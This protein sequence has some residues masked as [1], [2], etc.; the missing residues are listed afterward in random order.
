MPD[1]GVDMPVTPV[2]V[3]PTGQMELPVDPAVAGWYRF[4]A[5]AVSTE[6]NVVLAAHVDAPDYPIGPLARLRDAGVG[7]T[8]VVEASDGTSTTYAIESVTYY[9]KTTL[10]TD[11]LFARE[12]AKSLVIITCGGEFDS[13]TG[14]YR[15]NVVAIARTL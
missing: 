1:L 4:G 10:P 3:E 12:G 14:S 6:G 5:D 11:Q 2:G 13:S 15:D 9:E 7:S 8:V